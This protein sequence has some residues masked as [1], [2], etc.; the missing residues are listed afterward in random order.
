M[1]INDAITL[2]KVELSLILFIAACWGLDVFRKWR[3]KVMQTPIE[4]PHD[5]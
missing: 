4:E 2:S 3:N 5:D 1:I